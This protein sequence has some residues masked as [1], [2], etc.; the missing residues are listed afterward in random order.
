[1]LGVKFALGR[2]F[3]DEEGRPGKDNVVILSHR[4]WQELGG[5]ADAV[6]QFIKLNG[7]SYTL[8][9]VLAPG[10]S[11]RSLER[12]SVPLVVEGHDSDRSMRFFNVAGRLKSGI[13]MARAQTEMTA[14]AAQLAAQFPASNA[15]WSAV[16]KPFRNDRM[17]E[18]RQRTLWLLL[19]GTGFLLLIAYINTGNLLLADGVGRQREIAIRGSLGASRRLIF[20]QFLTEGLLLSITGWVGGIAAAFLVLRLFHAV[21]PPDELPSDADPHLN[22]VVALCALATA[23][24]AGVIFGCAPAWWAARVQPAEF[25]KDAARAGVSKGRRH[26]Q[27]LLL[28]AEFALSLT[29][30][31]GTG[32]AMHSLWLL[33]HVNV[34]VRIDHLFT[35]Y[36]IP[37]SLSDGATQTKI[38]A[39]YR[40]VLDSVEKVPGVRSTAV[41]AWRPLEGLNMQTPFSIA[42]EPAFKNPSEQPLADFQEISPGFLTTF[43]VQLLQGRGF[44]ATDTADTPKVVMVNEEFARTFLRGRDPLKERILMQDLASG[45]KSVAWQVIGVFRNVRT[46]GPRKANPEIDTDFWQSGFEYEG[47]AV[48]TAGDPAA[49]Q[50]R[51]AAAVNRAD[52]DIPLAMPKTMRDLRDEA[53][54]SDDFSTTLFGTFAIL[55]LSLAAVGMYGVIAFSVAQRSREIALR[56]AVGATRLDVVR[57]VLLE[58]AMVAGVGLGVAPMLDKSSKI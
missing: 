3:A 38:H 28:V 32:L 36:L 31:A 35:F 30:L 58:G 2:S 20:A 53:Y 54:A 17:P 40:R 50:K 33:T 6:G 44:A 7:K 27:R 45:G 56:V 14:F 49:M 43:G 5:R 39:Y 48:R 11:D 52:P 57:M 1:M 42:G 10:S 41:M 12:I 4:L 8:V 26:L 25:L 34:G 51:I 21:I 13:G 15:A 16:V 9:G 37:N 29:L 46:L 23:L 24:V 47:I 55:S 19:G 22:A 18:E